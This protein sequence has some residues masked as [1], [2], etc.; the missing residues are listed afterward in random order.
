[1]I[2]WLGKSRE[3]KAE[4]EGDLGAA[5]RLASRLSDQVI[6]LKKAMATKNLEI[7]ILQR[8]IEDLEQELSK[9]RREPLAVTGTGSFGERE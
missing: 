6:D 5:L 4:A 7:T 3:K 2:Q 8:H 1:M 9:R